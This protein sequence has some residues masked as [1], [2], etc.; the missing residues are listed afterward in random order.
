MYLFLF[1][2][3]LFLLTAGK[4]KQQLAISAVFFF[5]I[6]LAALLIRKKKQFRITFRISYPLMSCL[7]SLVLAAAFYLRWSTSGRMQPIADLLHMPLKQSC[8]VTALFLALLS[9]VGIDHLLK[10]FLSLISDKPFTKKPEITEIYV[11]LFLLLT[12]FLTIFLISR[13]SPFYPFNDWSDPNTMF[14]VGKGVLKGYVPYRDLYEQKGPML[15]F[16]HTFAAAVSYDS[17]IGIWILEPFFCFAFLFFAYKT[18]ALFTGKKSL[19]I[20]PFLTALIYSSQPFRAGDSAEE[21]ALPMLAYAFYI[22]CRT[23]TEKEMPSEKEYFFIG[24]GAGFVFWLKYSMTGMYLA[25]FLIMLFY[26]LSRH[27][28]QAFGEG[29]LLIISGVLLITLPIALYFAA[30]NALTALFE[31]YF[32]NNFVYYARPLSFPMKMKNGLDDYL[33]YFPASLVFIVMG[34]LWLA[35]R[36]KGQVL[37]YTL[38][39]FVFSFVF[40]FIGGAHVSYYLIILSPFCTF[41]FCALLDICTS[42]IPKAAAEAPGTAAFSAAALLA[43]TI[44]LCANSENPRFLEFSREDMFQYKMKKIIEEA[45]KPDVTILTM[46]V[47]ETGVNTVTKQIPDIRY[48]CFYNNDNMPEIKEVQNRCIKE[49]CADFIITRT[50]FDNVYPKYDTYEHR[51]AIVGMAD[52]TFEYFHYYTPKKLN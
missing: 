18:A 35:V 28:G 3:P 51:E 31:A 48:F 7:I 38:L 41:G 16:L 26:S 11:V 22:G 47:G 24:L 33:F 21:F 10:L 6:V 36:R 8:I 44:L 17:F 30:N 14:T 32:Y 2:L 37:V 40:A 27:K 49:Q 19:L 20:I 42:A 4:G 46:G 52:H 9:L 1:E 45:G 34:L 39:S 25:W 29:L 12:A 15:I 43:G 13:C 23:L 5:V 50:K